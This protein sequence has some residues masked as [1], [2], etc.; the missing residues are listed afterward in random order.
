MINFT[1]GEQLGNSR[2]R[3]GRWVYYKRVAQGAGTVYCLD[4]GGGYINLHM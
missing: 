4:S 1:N 3:D 2:V